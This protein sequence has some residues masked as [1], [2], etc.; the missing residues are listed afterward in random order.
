MRL[1]AG[2]ASELCGAGVR[3]LRTAQRDACTT[4]G[5]AAYGQLAAIR[6]AAKVQGGGTKKH[7][8]SEEVYG[9]FRDAA[10]ELRD[11]IDEVDG[12]DAIRSR[13]RPGPPPTWPCNVLALAAE[14]AEQY[15]ERKRELGVLDFNDLLIRARDLLGR[16]G[17]RRAAEAAGRADP[18]AAGRRVPGHRPA[19]GRVG[20]GAV[21][22]RVSPRQ[23][24]LRGRPQ[25]VDLS[26]PRRQPERVPRAARARLPERRAAAAFGELPQPAGDS[27]F[28]QRAVSPRSWDRTTSRCVPH[29]PQVG[30]DA[31]GRVPLGRDE[32][33]AKADGRQRR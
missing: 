6:E 29:R 23:A 12:A 32:E 7:W 27:G 8:V 9:A 19:A 4:A 11:A 18:A 5:D 25:A 1:P 15:D 33:G 26:L 30:L 17:A 28:R 13:R 24:V 14:V 10:K 22:Q 16:P 3:L 21:R 20:Q 2:A 31:G